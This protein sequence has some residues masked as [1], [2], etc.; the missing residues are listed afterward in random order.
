MGIKLSV[1][2]RIHMPAVFSFG[3][4]LLKFRAFKD[5][6]EQLGIYIELDDD[7]EFNDGE[8]VMLVDPEGKIE[9]E[10][11][12]V[13]VDDGYY[14]SGEYMVRI[15]EKYRTDKSDVDGLREVSQ[16][17]MVRLHEYRAMMKEGT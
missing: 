10:G 9:A 16:K 11:P 13:V 12:A 4:A 7:Q 8:Y 2:A 3:G 14:G 6:F 1:K 17:Q 5:A 15:P